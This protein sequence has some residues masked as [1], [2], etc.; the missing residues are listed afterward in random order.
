VAAPR[1]VAPKEPIDEAVVVEAASVVDQTGTV[2]QPVAS[3]P[4]VVVRNAAGNP[5]ANV[6][7]VFSGGITVAVLTGSDGIASTSW[8]LPTKPGPY[9]LVA[10]AGALTSV[11]F[12]ARASAGS[13][14]SLNAVTPLEQVLVSGATFAG[15]PEV[16][17]VD[18][19][20]NPIAGVDVAFETGS[21]GGTIE[22]AFDVT[23]FAGVATPGIWSVG[24]AV[25]VYTLTA[26]TAAIK[27]AVTLTARVSGPFV[28]SSIAAG[29]YAT[30]ANAPSG[31]T[32]CWGNGAAVP[33]PMQGNQRF[34]SLA[35]GGGF[36][37]GLTNNG[38]AYCW[39]RDF[40]DVK[41]ASTGPSAASFVA[42]RAVGGG[43]VFS[44]VTT[45]DTFACGLDEV[46]RA[47]CWGDNAFGQL[48]DGTTTIRTVP[49]PIIG[50]RIFAT[51]SAGLTHACGITA[52]SDT[53]CWGINN[54]RQLGD[55][56]SEKCITT[57]FDEYFNEYFNIYTIC[58]STPQRVRGA[59]AFV[60]VS[61]GEGTCGLTRDGSAYCWG[62][63]SGVEAVSR[64]VRFASVL[65]MG[66]YDRERPA[67]ITTMCGTT[68]E[69]AMYCRRS[70]ALD[71]VSVSTEI[72]FRSIAAG[73]EHQCG[74]VKD[75]N[76][77]RCWGQNRDG[78]LGNGSRNATIV[79]LS[80]V[81]PNP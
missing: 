36:A 76:E 43:I 15:P 20:G 50:D 78:Q 44:T 45:G 23:N 21:T 27:S 2:G 16:I 77:M 33:A 49:T 46:G 17:V 51:I 73:A 8:V 65:A 71:V 32:Y 40:T 75:S 66:F 18:Y 29:S 55:T 6:S 63:W 72:A 35:V 1:A 59:P 53:Y 48:G 67:V 57:Q 31:V 11:R 74:V 10:S 14:S 34:A 22:S 56:S 5:V 70:D 62:Y 19:V 47:Y 58:S 61:A 30:C 79:P 25:G 60:S 24:P 42:P 26:R 37:C 80:V 4:A 64:T 39:G 52:N 12:T 81:N 38:D 13:P 28:A 68:Q 9:A 3:P 54:A 7:V 41:T 69:G